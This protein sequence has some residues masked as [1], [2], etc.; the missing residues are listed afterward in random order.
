[1]RGGLTRS[2]RRG[3]AAARCITRAHIIAFS[4]LERIDVGETPTLFPHS[5]AILHCVK[6]YRPMGGCFLRY[7]CRFTP[8]W[9][10]RPFATPI[11]FVNRPGLR[12]SALPQ[13]PQPILAGAAPPTR[14][15]PADCSSHHVV[16]EAA[17]LADFALPP[18]RRR[19]WHVLRADDGVDSGQRRADLRP[20]L[21]G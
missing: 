8:H 17:E 20:Q 3:T 2:R 19:R 7:F 13:R 10:K 15:S 18:L 16:T 6:R 1:M 4:I 21:G 11:L 5:T 12:K 9:G 14:S